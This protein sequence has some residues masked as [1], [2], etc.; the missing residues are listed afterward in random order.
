MIKSSLSTS[1]VR[2]IGAL[3]LVV[4]VL[5]GCD[6]NKV[7]DDYVDIDSSVWHQDSLVSFELD[8][9]DN[10]L[11]HAVQ[12]NVRYITGYPFYNL[13]VTYYLEDSTG[14]I[15]D[16]E[17]QEFPIFDKKTGTPMGDGLG[18]I[19]DHQVEVFND[20]KFPYNG[21]YTFKV[22]QFMRPVELPGVMS[23]G[24]RIENPEE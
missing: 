12:Y 20:Y 22:K 16:S 6:S 5:S 14:N 7:Y 3:I 13:F 23:F 15:I 18:D 1:C 2:G 4:V 24:L 10:Q 8:I 11:E 21:S 17:L 9:Q 19:F